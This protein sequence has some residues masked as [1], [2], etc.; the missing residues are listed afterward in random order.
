[1]IDIHA[2]VLPG[3]DDGPA[4]LGEAVE[5]AQAA[6]EDGIDTVVA[7][8]HM[9]DGVY[10][11]SREAVFQA[12]GRLNDALSEHGLP[13]SVLA[14][15]DVHAEADVP[16]LLRDG[17]LVTVA[18]RGKHL[19]LELPT[20]VVPR[21]LH[22]L[23]FHVQLQGVRPVISHPERNRV[24]QD[25]P[26]ELL[27]LVEAGCLTQVTAA[28]ILGDFGSHVQECA[29]RLFEW[30]MVHFVATD[31]HGVRKR[32][33]KLRAAGERVREL[34]GDDEA[35]WIL[36][37]NPGALVHGEYV[38]VPEPERPPAKKRWFLW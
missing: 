10:D 24:I 17:R 35:E 34:I 1:M 14:G 21:E 38:N 32:R 19:L 27:S 13:L 26:A 3:L 9:L 20:D 37:R 16:G 11:A 30:R 15:A 5:L 33:P 4:N 31:M 6:V 2:H 25:D 8:P 28:S 22:Q 23:L 36:Q 12:L 7:T 18:D 29:E